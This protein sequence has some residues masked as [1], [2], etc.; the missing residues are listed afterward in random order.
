MG[1]SWHQAH[2]TSWVDAGSLVEIHMTSM[3]PSGDM[4]GDVHEIKIVGRLVDG[5]EVV[6]AVA[7]NKDADL[8]RTLAAREVTRWIDWSREARHV[9]RPADRS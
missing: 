7:R 5:G 2:G 4:M 6:L 3:G 8:L 9:L 1:V